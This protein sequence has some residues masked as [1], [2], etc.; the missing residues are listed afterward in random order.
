M[1]DRQFRDLLEYL[2]RSWK[3]YRKVRKGV[4]KRIGRHMQSLGCRNLEAYL[5]ALEADTAAREACE[6]LMCVSVSRFFRDGRLWEILEA[7]ILPSLLEAGADPVRAW[8]AGCACGEEVYSL[9]MLWERRMRTGERHP[10]LEITGTDMNPVYLERAVRA[11]YTVSSL[12]EVPEDLRRNCFRAGADARTLEVS[13]PLREGIRWRVMDLRAVPPG[14][15][16]HLVLLRNGLLTYYEKAHQRTALEGILRRLTP[17]GF[18]VIGSH[19]RLPD[20]RTDLTPYGGLPYVFRK[21]G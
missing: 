1:D 3:G 16:F 13:R 5:C 18:L 7:R 11:L 17:G 9:K 20:P 12:R 4:K 6:R 14:G 19:E 15:P 2:G 21:G 8:C 10:P